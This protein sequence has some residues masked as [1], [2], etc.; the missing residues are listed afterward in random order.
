M[1]CRIF[2]VGKGGRTGINLYI[3][4]ETK[5]RD[6]ELEFNTDKWIVK[7]KKYQSGMPH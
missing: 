6:G 1:I 4:P 3:D 5:R 7:P 2:N